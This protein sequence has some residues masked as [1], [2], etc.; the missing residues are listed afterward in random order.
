[1]L[2]MFLRPDPVGPP[3]PRLSKR[4]GTGLDGNRRYRDH[5]RDMGQNYKKTIKGES[6][7]I[8]QTIKKLSKNYKNYKR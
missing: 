6:I 5:Y 2:L 1:M 7:K 4:I 3:V 8:S